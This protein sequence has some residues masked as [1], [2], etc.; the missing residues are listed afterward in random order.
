MNP[1]QL[2]TTCDRCGRELPLGATKYHA[3]VEIT[4]VWDGFLP[5]SA[6]DESLAKLVEETAKMDEET[7]ENQVHMEI[8]LT[9]CPQCRH[10]LLVVL[11]GEDG[12]LIGLKRKRKSRLQ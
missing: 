1:K 10:K 5:A 8:D 4:S 11:G 12:T 9:L 6:R 3:F 2:A 7:L